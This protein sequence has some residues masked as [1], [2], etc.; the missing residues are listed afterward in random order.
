MI[1]TDK[2]TSLS[3]WSISGEEKSFAILRSSKKVA[4]NNFFLLQYSCC[5]QTEEATGANPI[6]TLH[7]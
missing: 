6:E 1:A 4:K 7:A 3:I 2:R 5:K